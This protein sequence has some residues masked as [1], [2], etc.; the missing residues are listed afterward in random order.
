MIMKFEICNYKIFKYQ[1]FCKA[2]DCNRFT[3]KYRA[4]SRSIC[5]LRQK[6]PK[7]IAVVIH[8]RTS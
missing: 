5:N 8:N 2:K 6:V 4:A 3:R 1:K 7:E